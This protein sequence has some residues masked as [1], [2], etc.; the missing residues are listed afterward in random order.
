MNRYS[1][2]AKR[3]DLAACFLK[4]SVVHIRNDDLRPSPGHSQS[5]SFADPTRT[6]RDDGHLAFKLHALNLLDKWAAALTEARR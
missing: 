6:T 3:G 5:G 2:A 4:P 1:A